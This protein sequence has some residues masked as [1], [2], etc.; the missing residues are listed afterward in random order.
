M[1]RTYLRY[2]PAWVQLVVLLLFTFGVFVA[3]GFA[4]SYLVSQATGV[5]IET[6]QEI[7]GG[8]AS[9]PNTRQVLIGLQ[10]TQFITLFLLPS[11]LFAWRADPE[12]L[13]FAGFQKP[14]HRWF[15]V[16][17]L[18][19]VLL[20]TYLVG[21]LALV[22]KS[23]PLSEAL[24]REEAAKTTAISKIAIAHNLPQLL[25]NIALIGVLP[26]I[27]EE[28]FFRGMLQRILIQLFKSPWAGIIIT[29]VIFSAIHMQFS[30]FLPRMALGVVLGALYWYSGSLWPGILFHF[31]YNSLGVIGLYFK[32]DM[33]QKDTPFEMSDAL[34]YTM[35]ALS[36]VATSY[37]VLKMR[38]K[39][40]TVYAKVYPAEAPDVFDRAG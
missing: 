2:Q 36:L 35:G 11:L 8:D 20:G 34:I 6:M 24:V 39:S 14:H 33:L 23:I 18:L 21:A 5:N 10:L 40:K 29:G 19:L 15:Y 27:G 1:L 38:T 28:L 32:P 3:G 12:P 31:L 17:A 7:S 22:N 26:A 30:G 16:A 37:L 4:G 9:H 25:L 13:R